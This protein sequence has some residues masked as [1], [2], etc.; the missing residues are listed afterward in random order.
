LAEFRTGGGGN[1]PSDDFQELTSLTFNQT[2]NGVAIVTLS[3]QAYSVDKNSGGNFVGKEYSAMLTRVLLDGSVLPPGVV[4]FAD[5]TGRKSFSGGEASYAS[6]F[7]WADTVSPG[8]HTLTVQIR[9]LN[10]W[11]ES[12]FKKWT[13]SVLHG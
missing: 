3:G 8:T 10:V 11:D 1:T 9:S 2:T 7:E 6:S 12:G 13:L 4:R 5:N